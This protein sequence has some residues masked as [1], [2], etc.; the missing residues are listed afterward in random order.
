MRN[1]IEIPFSLYPRFLFQSDG[2]INHCHL[3]FSTDSSGEINRHSLEK[4]VKIYSE[5]R[6][7]RYVSGFSGS[8]LEYQKPWR[9]YTDIPGPMVV[10][11]VKAKEWYLSSYSLQSKSLEIANGRAGIACT[12]R[13]DRDFSYF[14]EFSYLENI[15]EGDHDGY[16][17]IKS[18]DQTEIKIT[19]K[20]E[21]KKIFNILSKKSQL[22]TGPNRNWK[23]PAG[24]MEI[25][26]NVY[27]PQ[28]LDI[29][30]R[31]AIL[32][33]EYSCSFIHYPKTFQN[34]NLN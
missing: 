27:Y 17:V 28:T 14:C 15:E 30:V 6:S 16:S 20:L 11:H 12:Q 10:E 26:C 19:D 13:Y 5:I 1:D 2:E 34:I 9:I 25:S 32:N 31:T 18:K 33:E 4:E 22:E 23:T 21:A 24:D 7:G 3:S 8:G 29:T